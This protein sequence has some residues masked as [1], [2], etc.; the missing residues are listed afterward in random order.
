MASAHRSRGLCRLLHVVGSGHIYTERNRSDTVDQAVWDPR[1]GDSWPVLR[2]A[3]RPPRPGDDTPRRGRARD[4]HEQV[5]DAAVE[6]CLV[7]GFG[8]TS[9]EAIAVRAGVSKTTVYERTVGRFL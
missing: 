2:P 4:R 6:V 1:D 8:H 5:I 7:N 9:M 3:R